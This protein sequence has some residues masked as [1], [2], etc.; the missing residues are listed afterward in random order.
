MVDDAT[1]WEAFADEMYGGSRIPRIPDIIG[2]LWETCGLKV[3]SAIADVCCGRGYSTIELALRGANV[4][5]V[6]LSEEFIVNL[7]QAA[8]ALNLG[9]VARQGNA[10]KMRVE[11]SVCATMILWNSLGHQGPDTDMKI[12]SNA[13]QST[14]SSG[15][16][17]VEL[18][19]L[20]E[21][22]RES[23]KVTTRSIGESHTFRRIR[24]LDTQ[25]GILSADWMI[26]DENETPIRSGHFSQRIYPKAEI[27]RMMNAAGWVYVT[28]SDRVPLPCEPTGTLFIGM[29]E[30]DF[31]D[32]E[33]CMKCRGIL[34]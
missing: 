9:I 15:S 11:D 17:V 33:R 1:F 22:S 23:H 34:P 6:D 21:L 7:N 3:G 4:Q 10:E 2:V 27:V 5:A 14:H 30:S 18:T 25:T 28:D 31:P 26:F 12:L 29:A 16:L 32:S 13:R 20:E 24:N 8:N 19:T